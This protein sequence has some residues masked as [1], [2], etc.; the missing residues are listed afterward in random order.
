MKIIKNGGLE[1]LVCTAK[2]PFCGCEFEYNRTDVI[3]FI[4]KNRSIVGRK[5]KCPECN[6]ILS[7]GYKDIES[8]RDRLPPI[9][10]IKEYGIIYVD[11][12]A[13]VITEYIGVVDEIELYIRG[14]TSKIVSSETIS[15]YKDDVEE[16]ETK[17][18]FNIRN[19]FPPFDNK[20]SFKVFIY[21]RYKNHM[22]SI[23]HII[24]DRLDKIGRRHYEQYP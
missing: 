2:C 20:L 3:E 1:G 6:T 22:N 9:P 8:I 17:L 11:G 21:S 23:Y 5:V 15:L 7:G 18:N 14:I 10:E 24:E 4:I 13:A 12:D 16:I 19:R